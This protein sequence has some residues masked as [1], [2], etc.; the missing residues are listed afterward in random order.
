MT[1]RTFVESPDLLLLA[2]TAETWSCRPSELLGDSVRPDA[3]VALQ[4]DVAAA[5]VLWRWKDAK[6]KAINGA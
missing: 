6:L 4:I 1:S 5:A 3:T 2:Q